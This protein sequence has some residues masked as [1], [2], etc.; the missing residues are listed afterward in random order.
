[1]S[2]LS[3]LSVEQS[4][5]HDNSLRRVSPG[6]WFH[7]IVHAVRD[8]WS[9]N[10]LEWA[11]SLA[12]YGFIS[13]FPLLTGILIVESYVVDSAW[14]A[15][16]LTDL[17]KGFLPEGGAQTGDIL[18]SAVSERRRVGILSLVIFFLTGRRVLGVLAKGLNHVSDVDQQDVSLLRR[19]ATELA[20][21]TGLVTAGLLAL[22]ARPLL[23]LAW[24]TARFIPGP[25]NPAVNVMTGIFRVIPIMATFVL[26]YAFVP[27]GTRLWR[28]V[29]IG[30][31]TATT[32]FLIAQAM[33][34]VMAGRIWNTL[35]LLYGPLALAALLL[36]WIWYVAVI[37]LAC[38]GFASHIKVMLLEGASV[39]RSREQ[40]VQG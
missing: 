8:L 35:G 5:H 9:V 6:Q 17:L 3:K 16:H 14:V 29:F 4:D 30:A 21:F 36:S 18:E 11:S 22:T 25:D 2:T 37:T 38:G 23:N 20:L 34:N 28:A 27:H 32:L 10:V 12:F 15:R 19:L 13:A 31:G 26:V 33:F 39:E 7:V 40:H 1:M 24:E